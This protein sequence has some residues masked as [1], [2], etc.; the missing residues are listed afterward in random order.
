MEILKHFKSLVIFLHAKKTKIVTSGSFGIK[1]FG[2]IFGLPS[3]AI[4]E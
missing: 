2:I 1:I 4:S 3:T